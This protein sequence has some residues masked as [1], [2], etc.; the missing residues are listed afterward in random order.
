MGDMANAIN[1]ADLPTAAEA[2]K[3][4]VQGMEVAKEKGVV[5]ETTVKEAEIVS[6]QLQEAADK[7]KNKD[8]AEAA[9]ILAYRGI[10][11]VN[12]LD[13]SD[14]ANDRQ[15]L[16]Q[17]TESL[18]NQL[19]NNMEAM[20][21]ALKNDNLYLAAKQ[22]DEAAG[23]CKKLSSLTHDRA[24]DQKADRM[25]ELADGMEEAAN[26]NDADRANEIGAEMTQISSEI[27]SESSEEPSRERRGIATEGVQGVE[28]SFDQSLPTL[29]QSTSNVSPSNQPNQHQSE[30]S[31]GWTKRSS[32]VDDRKESDDHYR[33]E[34]EEEHLREN[35]V[36]EENLERAEQI[37]DEPVAKT[38]EEEK[39][40]MEKGIEEVIEADPE[41]PPEEKEAAKEYTVRMM[42]EGFESAQITNGELVAAVDHE[43]ENVPEAANA[44]EDRNSYYY[45]PHY[46]SSYRFRNC[47]HRYSYNRCK[48]MLYGDYA[49]HNGYHHFYRRRPY[50]GRRRYYYGRRHYDHK[51]HH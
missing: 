31:A 9:K 16:D 41:I 26:E 2:G 47:L 30:S 15:A 51:Q 45:A 5:A 24:D 29:E 17:E 49:Y 12:A 8:A 20:V 6:E 18:I 36:V 32:P 46:Y 19:Q 22:A 3:E 50:Y 25:A 40:L 42:Q 1:R 27:I 48:Q 35:P 34:A 44:M 23:T 28:M 14:N 7:G 37:R 10:E 38:L 11:T 33:T 4:V 39:E 21:Q 13:D 43:A